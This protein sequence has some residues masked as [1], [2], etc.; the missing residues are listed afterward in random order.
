MAGLALF[1]ADMAVAKEK[2]RVAGLTWPGYG[3]WYIIKEKNL[4]PTW[5]SNTRQSRIR[6]KASA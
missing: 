5:T 1:A 6:S 3:W 4:R 2:V